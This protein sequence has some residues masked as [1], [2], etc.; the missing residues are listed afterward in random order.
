MARA[1]T[2]LGSQV[3]VETVAGTAVPA[4]LSLRG[5]SVTLSP[6][7]ST[8]TFRPQGYAY[9]TSTL[10]VK[11]ETEGTV[12]GPM[13]FDEFGYVLASAYGVPVSTVAEADHAWQHVF[14]PDTDAPVNSRSS[15]TVQFG[16]SDGCQ[17]AAGCFV[18]SFE[19]SVE[20][21]GSDGK[22]DVKAS[23]IG[24]ATTT[25]TL[26]ATPTETAGHRVS[27]LKFDVKVAS[28]VAGLAGAS[29]ASGITAF[30]FK[31]EGLAENVHTV[32]SAEASASET[33]VGETSREVTMTVIS[34]T[35]ADGW[36]SN[37]AAACNTPMYIR[38]SASGAPCAGGTT[39]YS[40][41]HDVA[42]RV[43]NVSEYK[44][45]DKTIGYDITFTPIVDADGFA[46]EVTLV[47]AVEAY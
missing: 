16:D 6:K 13:S 30:G 18:S 32:K 43:T 15:W 27:P 7:Y 46:E 38:V 5:L 19:Y 11:Q 44:D 14:T 26:T 25:T 37:I 2:H 21:G 40:F 47:N 34:S 10:L 33:V 12:E 4:D 41:Q 28:T 20:R 9:D 3:G 31:A 39:D 17:Q 35:T 8:D 1:Y 45:V 22:A 36:V 29:A 24:R 42:V 23:L